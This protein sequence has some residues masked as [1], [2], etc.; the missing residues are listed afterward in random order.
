MKTRTLLIGLVL[1]AVQLVHLEAP[2]Q[3]TLYVSNLGQPSTGNAAVASDAWLAALFQTGTNS[4]GY[5]LNSI[6]LLMTAAS[7]SPNGFSVSL[8]SFNVNSGPENRLG[9]LSGAANPSA[10]G[11]FTYTTS[12]LTLSPSS[13]YWVVLTAATPVAN[14]SYYWSGA[15]SGVYSSSGGWFLSGGSFFSTDGLSS[16]WSGSR[17]GP[18]PF[19]LA[20]N[21]T[22]IP[23][24]SSLVLFGL[25]GM[26]L[27]LVAKRR[28]RQNFQSVVAA[29][30]EK[31]AF[32]R[33]KPAALC[34]GAATIHEH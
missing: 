23:E 4:A 7:G 8:Y 24:P 20:I 1:V 29:V 19:Q 15:N 27:A 14:G 13:N 33:I 32:P 12:S 3:G 21:A 10:G 17:T 31:A 34:R 28:T 9:S 25:G 6:Q 16:H 18:G 11:L 26:Y 5:V 22:A 30:R 2:A